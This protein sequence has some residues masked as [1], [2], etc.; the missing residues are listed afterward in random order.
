MENKKCL[1]PPTSIWYDHT[2]PEFHFFP[3]DL[4]AHLKLNGL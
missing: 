2:K 4:V 3:Y 1:K